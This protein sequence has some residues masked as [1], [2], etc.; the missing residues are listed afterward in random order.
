MKPRSRRRSTATSNVPTDGPRRADRARV[1][2]RLGGFRT[3]GGTPLNDVHPRASSP[4]SGRRRGQAGERSG[5]DAR[6]LLDHQRRRLS[7]RPGRGTRGVGLDARPLHERASRAVRSSG[8]PMTSTAPTERRLGD[9][10]VL[11]QRPPPLGALRHRP[12]SA[13]GASRRGSRHGG[14]LRHRSGHD[15]TGSPS[16]R[17]QPRFRPS[18]RL[19]ARVASCCRIQYWEAPGRPDRPRWVRVPYKPV[20]PEQVYAGHV[21]SITRRAPRSR[22]SSR[23]KES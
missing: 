22:A 20:L 3:C 13:R 10:D 8:S 5:E 19:V 11:L 2:A 15:D 23:E 17:R 14:A 6:L 21:A 1:A 18:W 9:D 4:R 7:G 12:L 16:P